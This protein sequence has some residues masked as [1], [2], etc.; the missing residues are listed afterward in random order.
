M[1]RAHTGLVSG[2]NPPTHANELAVH[3]ELRLSVPQSSPWEPGKPADHPLRHRAR[4]GG[5]CL[6]RYGPHRNPTRQAQRAPRDGLGRA[7]TTMC[8]PI[9]ELLIIY[10]GGFVPLG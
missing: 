1:C 8:Y 7:R 6:L 5:M 9:N 4:N 10:L 3:R 2:A